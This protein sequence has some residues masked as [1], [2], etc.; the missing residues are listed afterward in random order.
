[1]IY[2]HPAATKPAAL[3]KLEQATGLQAQLHQ[4]RAVL[5]PKTVISFAITKPPAHPS[6]DWTRTG[7]AA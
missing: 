1:M 4:H 5:V 6:Q 2:I 3:A 7:G